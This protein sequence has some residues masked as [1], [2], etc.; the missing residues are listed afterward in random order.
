MKF[1]RWASAFVSYAYGLFA[2]YRKQNNGLRILLYHSIGTQLSHDRYGISISKRLFERQIKSLIE[3]PCSPDKSGQGIFDRKEVCHFQIRSLTTQQ[4]TGNALAFAVQNKAE[5]TPLEPPSDKSLGSRTNNKPQIAI[6][7]DDG[8][9]D[10]LYVVAPILLKH[11]I[12]FTVFVTAGFVDADSSMYLNKA[13]LKEL[14]ELQGVT[15]GSHGMSHCPL[16]QL[17]DHDLRAELVESRSRIEDIIG[18]KVEILSYPHGKVNR[19]VL[20]CAI[21]SGYRLGAGSR[22]GTNLKNRDFMLLRRTEIWGTD[23]Q[24]IFQQKCVGAWDWYGY[25]QK[26][27]GM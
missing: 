14:S 8:F 4:A 5:F 15:I 16:T 18:R 12:P 3:A 23:S 10:N 13:E 19:R 21:E 2:R 6:T 22:F 1:T 27:R 17:D 24:D 9:K 11:N 20:D 26:L 25:Y 7:F